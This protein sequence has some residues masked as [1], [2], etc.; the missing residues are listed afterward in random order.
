M[1]WRGLVLAG[2]LTASGLA[3]ARVTLPMLDA[4]QIKASCDQALAVGQARANALTTRQGNILLDWDRTAASV[5][6]AVGPIYVLAYVHPDKAVRDAGEA[7]IVAYTQFETSLYQNEALYQRVQAVEPADA[8]DRKFKQDLLNAFADSGVG[9]P[10]AKRERAAAILT[11]IQS[12]SQQF[13]RNIR[14]NDQT[15]SF[16]GAQLAGLPATYLEQRGVESGGTLTVG[17]DSPDYAPFMRSARDEGAR[18]RYY[19]AFNRRGGAANLELLDRIV[20][21]RFEYAQLHD[22]ASFSDFVLKR[23]MVG[24]PARLERFLDEVGAVTRDAEA[25]DVERLRAMKAK[26]LGK[27]LEAV[28][29]Q[30]WDRSYY[31][32][33]YRQQTAKIDQEALRAYFPSLA[34]RDWILAVTEGQYSVRFVPADVPVWHEDVTYY[35]VVD[36]RSGELLSGIYL[37]L[38]PR[39][40]KYKHAAA[41]PVRG[42]SRA[43]DRLPIS[44]LV[45]NFDRQGLTQSE[46]ETF[47][48]EFGHGVHG[49]LSRT[50]YVS[51]AGTSVERDFVEAPSQMF[52]EWARRPESL[53]LLQQF[54][55][56]CPQLDAE[57]IER[58]DV[59]RRLASGMRY[60]RQHLYASYDFALYRGE[61]QP[62]MDVWKQ[63]TAATP[64]GYAPET[65]FP[66]AFSHIAGSYASGYYGYMWS[67]AIALDMLSAFGASVINP[68][69]GQRFRT[70]IL[71][72]GSERPAGEMVQDFLGRPP[73][74]TAFF[75]EVRGQRSAITR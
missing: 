30:Q 33:Q 47:F 17:F 48:H 32:E 22:L 44:V 69:V 67:E 6:T 34:V 29:L 10:P 27:P 59:A 53:A 31:I 4:K 50:R 42:A 38:F 72:R 63:M 55:S 54:C 52:E 71:A 5:E 56:G 39:D 11:E 3:S 16:S 18:Q 25:G 1:I 51:Q 61:P 49:V 13:A 62:A 75:E 15:L 36:A 14:E 21:L 28:T 65:Q 37:D 74:N 7:C 73:S 2:L 57:Q 9:L 19:T 23:R 68:Q 70:L 40:G 66:G 45:T 43:Q 20:Q 58:L 24:G 60:A 26:D 35:D 12:L 41:F 64:Y 46:V 8:I